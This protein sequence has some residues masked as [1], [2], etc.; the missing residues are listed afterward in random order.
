ML[1]TTFV[2]YDHVDLVVEPKT[3]AQCC[4]SVVA[5]DTTRGLAPPQR[6]LI[7]DSCG[8]ND[9]TNKNES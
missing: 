2:E 4:R 5:L 6:T 8:D 7:N 1:D 3:V 9:E